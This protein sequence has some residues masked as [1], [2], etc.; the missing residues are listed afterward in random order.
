M[1]DREWPSPNAPNTVYKNITTTPP[2]AEEIKGISGQ[3]GHPNSGLQIT[4]LI[5]L[6]FKIISWQFS[7]I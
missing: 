5:Y 4:H 7:H 6:S 3:Q 1:S 2:P